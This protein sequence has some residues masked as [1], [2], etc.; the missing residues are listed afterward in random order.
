MKNFFKMFN[1]KKGQNPTWGIILKV[2]LA[3]IILVVVL[4]LI[5]K[6]S[7]WISKVNFG[8]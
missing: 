6:G 5:V 4:L 8:W 7:D 3:I 1:N 2:V